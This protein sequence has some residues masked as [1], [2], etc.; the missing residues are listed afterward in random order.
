V[1]PKSLSAHLDKS[2][3]QKATLETCYT[4]FSCT[5]AFLNDRKTLKLYLSH[6]IPYILKRLGA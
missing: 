6:L 5:E 3:Q 4:W 1:I 2:L